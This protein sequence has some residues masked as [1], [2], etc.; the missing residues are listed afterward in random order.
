[1]LEK[2]IH[3]GSK[4]GNNEYR[5]NKIIIVFWRIEFIIITREIAS[6]RANNV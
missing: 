5:D 2:L 1:M 4:I 6:K 3:M